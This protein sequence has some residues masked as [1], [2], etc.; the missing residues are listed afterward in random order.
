MTSDSEVL[1]PHI[2]AVCRKGVHGWLSLKWWLAD[3]GLSLLFSAAVPAC[4]GPPHPKRIRL[5]VRETVGTFTCPAS[6][7]CSALPCFQRGASIRNHPLRLLSCIVHISVFISDIVL[8]PKKKIFFVVVSLSLLPE[9]AYA[10]MGPVSR[11]QH[12]KVHTPNHSVLNSY[13]LSFWL[14]LW[15]CDSCWHDWENLASSSAN[16]RTHK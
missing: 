14:T 11:L 7:Y 12:Q 4:C 1:W 5:A 10:V 6:M 16:A 3:I 13:S 9:I 15:N 8:P 2:Q